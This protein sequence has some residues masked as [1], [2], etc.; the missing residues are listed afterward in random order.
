[1]SRTGITD[2]AEIEVLAGNI[3][4]V[5]IRKGSE[6]TLESA[7]RMVLLLEE[8][9]DQ[10]IPYRAGM[11]DISNIVYIN[12]DARNYLEANEDVRGRVTAI[13][14]ISTSD[15][16]RIIGNLILSLV[17]T[18]G[19]PTKL[20]RSPIR[21]EHWLRTKMAEAMAADDYRLKVA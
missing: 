6:V 21:A 17:E 1:M 10:S 3:C 8:L 2:I 11:F 7:K 19:N 12:E 4:H 13:A 5:T 16:G 18:N 14:L 15:L 20:F 9:T